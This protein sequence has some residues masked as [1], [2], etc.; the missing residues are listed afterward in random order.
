MKVFRTSP[1]ALLLLL[2][3]HETLEACPSCY[4]AAE[5]PMTAGMNTAILV[6]LGI[7]GCVLAIISGTFVMLWRR[8]KRRAAELSDH[9]FVDN[10]GVLNSKNEKGVLWNSF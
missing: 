1:I 9:A 10:N 7:T 2:G 6:M 5:S 4:G 3:F 8:G